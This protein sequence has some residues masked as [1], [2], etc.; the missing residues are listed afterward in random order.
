MS[1]NVIRKRVEL[2]QDDVEWFETQYPEGSL[3]GI[4]TMLF[5]KFREVNTLSPQ[6][7]AKIAAE[8]LTEQMKS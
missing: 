1:R 7:Y 5:S 3:G 6:D 8:A 2:N 4:I